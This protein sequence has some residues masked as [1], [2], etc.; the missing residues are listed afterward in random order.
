[1]GRFLRICTR[2]LSLTIFYKKENDQRRKVI[3]GEKKIKTKD[4]MQVIKK[5]RFMWL[6][7]VL[8]WHVI[9]RKC[10]FGEEKLS[11]FLNYSVLYPKMYAHTPKHGGFW[12]QLYGIT[13][14]SW[15][16]IMNLDV[17]DVCYIFYIQLQIQQTR[18]KDAFVAKKITNL[19]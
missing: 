10:Y 19:P 13:L 7:S 11:I 14:L 12:S 4:K 16:K 6:I 9:H 3:D 8:K 2:D 15:Q 1:M 5:T 18:R 17:C